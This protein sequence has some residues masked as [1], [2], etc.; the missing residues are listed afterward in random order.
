MAPSSE[1]VKGALRSRKDGLNGVGRVKACWRICGAGIEELQ[2]E[3]G[4]WGRPCP[5]QAC[6]CEDHMHVA[7]DPLLLS[8]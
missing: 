7:V 8:A 6:P 2:E 1:D 3:I 5:D 4:P